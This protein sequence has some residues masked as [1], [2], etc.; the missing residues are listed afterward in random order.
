[1]TGPS[2]GWTMRSPSDGVMRAVPTCL[3]KLEVHSPADKIERSVSVG[4]CMY[5]HR[6]AR[7]I[8]HD[9]I[10]PTASPTDARRTRRRAPHHL[11]GQKHSSATATFMCRTDRPVDIT[12]DCTNHSYCQLSLHRGP[13]RPYAHS[14]VLHRIHANFRFLFVSMRMYNRC[15]Q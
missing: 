11:A 6:Q 14:G 12:T 1:M 5:H 15:M 9:E 8:S 3:I 7:C 4:G 13:S 2:S 10:P